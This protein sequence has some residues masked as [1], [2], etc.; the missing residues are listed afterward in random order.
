MYSEITYSEVCPVHGTG[1]DWIGMHVVCLYVWLSCLTMNLLFC[2]SGHTGIP[3]HINLSYFNNSLSVMS[4]FYMCMVMVIISDS[5]CIG[6][7]MAKCSCKSK[8]M[9]FAISWKNNSLIRMNNPFSFQ[10]I[11]IRP[12]QVHSD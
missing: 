9:A 1:L 8:S 12:V 10:L 3:I 6:L 2:L 4:L 7:A 11:V 5:S